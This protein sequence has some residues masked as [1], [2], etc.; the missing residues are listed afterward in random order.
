ML[1]WGW[2]KLVDAFTQ[3]P[4]DPANVWDEIL[5]QRESKEQDNSITASL[6]C[7][8]FLVLWVMIR[9]RTRWGVYVLLVQSVVVF[10][11][12]SWILSQCNLFPHEFCLKRLKFLPCCCKSWGSNENT[13]ILFLQICCYY[14]WVEVN[15]GKG[16]KIVEMQ[17]SFCTFAWNCS[18]LVLRF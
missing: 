15:R 18:G 17:Q 11:P 14:L 12:Y 10:N 7:S 4:Y 13:G 5:L 2:G 3:Q 1:Y 6:V 9:L 16:L 8:C